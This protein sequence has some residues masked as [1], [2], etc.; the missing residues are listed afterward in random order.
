MI[1][2]ESSAVWNGL[3]FPALVLDGDRQVLAR[4]EG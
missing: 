4:R 2:V 3:P 1:S